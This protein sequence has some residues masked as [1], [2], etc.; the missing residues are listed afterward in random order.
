ME[1]YFNQYAISLAISL[2]GCMS[3]VVFALIKQGIQNLQEREVVVVFL[4]FTAICSA[5]KI[6]YLA[7]DIT[8][9][10]PDSKVDLIFLAMG[11]I[12]ILLV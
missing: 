4:D 8:I 10:R 2:L 5:A 7:F 12:V 1:K 3:Y 6:I 9:C 11:A